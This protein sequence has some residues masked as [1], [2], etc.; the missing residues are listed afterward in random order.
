MPPTGSASW[1][2]RH[3][4]LGPIRPPPQQASGELGRMLFWL[5]HASGPIALGILTIAL[6]A[7]L[8]GYVVSAL[9]WRLWAHLKARGASE[10]R[11]AIDRAARTAISAPT[12]LHAGN[13]AHAQARHRPHRRHLHRHR[14]RR[15][16]RRDPA[17]TPRHAAAAT[18]AIRNM[19]RFGFDA[20]GMDRN[21][22]PGDSFYRYANGNW[23]RTTEIPADR[24]NYGMFIT[25]D[26]LSRT[27][28]HDILEEAARTPGSR[29]GDFYASFMDEAAVNAAGIAPIRPL[30]AEIRAIRDRSQWAAE[31]GRMLRRS[32]R[33]ARS[34]AASTA[35]SASRPR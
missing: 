7:A 1:E 4:A 13:I 32:I 27:R 3:E 29:I 24:S 9:V 12:H 33:A 35:T 34:T 16:L 17:A 2:L 10:A 6:G 21:V 28:T 31:L 23:D 15:R 18:P 20:A 22:A 8:G 5:H 14:R 19:A 25:L 30:L 11:R 26:D